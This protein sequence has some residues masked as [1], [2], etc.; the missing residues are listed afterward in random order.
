MQPLG[1]FKCT[2]CGRVAVGVSCAQPVK[3]VD[4]FE[5]YLARL[6]ADEWSNY[7]NDRPE[8]LT[9]YLQC[10]ACRAPPSAFVLAVL[11]DAQT[12]CTLGVI[13]IDA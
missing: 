3:S 12:G 10:Q 7:P 2:K 4:N 6:T 9:N 1:E 8:M 5:A 11:D 13:A